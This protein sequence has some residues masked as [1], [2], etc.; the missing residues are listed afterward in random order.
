[1]GMCLVLAACNTS[2]KYQVGN[3]QYETGHMPSTFGS[4]ISGTQSCDV[5]ER[6]EKGDCPYRQ[7]MLTVQPGLFASI[8]GPM[9][10]A[11]SW[12]Y[13]GHE[14]GSG[15]AKSG[16]NYNASANFR[17]DQ[18]VNVRGHYGHR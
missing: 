4:T 14:I 18:G 6:D 8:F 17:A 16:S 2:G 3:T 15:L 5:L 9:V 7:P 13:A 10:Q 1:M 11:A 12:A